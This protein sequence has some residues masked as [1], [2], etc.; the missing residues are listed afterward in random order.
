ME[1][2]R[3]PLFTVFAVTIRV[4]SVCKFTS[5]LIRMNGQVATQPLVT[6]GIDLW[7]HHPF[8]GGIHMERPVLTEGFILL[9]ILFTTCPLSCGSEPILKTL[10]TYSSEIHTVLSTPVFWH[11]YRFKMESWHLVWMK[12]SVCWVYTEVENFADTVAVKFE[13]ILPPPQRRG[14]FLWLSYEI[15]V[16]PQFYKLASIFLAMEIIQREYSEIRYVWS[17]ITIKQSVM[18]FE[19]T[20]R[21]GCCQQKKLLATT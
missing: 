14:I 3:G 13:Q 5:S 19:T 9:H 7:W 12:G 8:G 6:E 4:T 2:Q 18:L 17:K 1:V 21:T 15:W 16:G 20:S 11:D 10:H